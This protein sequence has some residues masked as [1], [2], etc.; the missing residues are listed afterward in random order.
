MNY[1]FWQW[2]HNCIAHPLEGWCVLL[3]GYTPAWVDRFH[4][5]AIPGEWRAKRAKPKR[6]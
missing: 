5:W 2:T 3:L 6:A 1:R 4:D